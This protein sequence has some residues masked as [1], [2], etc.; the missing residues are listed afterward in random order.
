MR[1][2]DPAVRE[3]LRKKCL[4]PRSDDYGQLC[5]QLSKVLDAY[6]RQSEQLEA[7]NALV[8][9]HKGL[10]AD[11]TASVGKFL[12]DLYVIMVDPLSEGTIKIDVVCEALTIAAKTDRD[13]IHLMQAQLAE[14]DKTIAEKDAEI[15]GLREAASH[16]A[17]DT[18]GSTA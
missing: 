8:A 6:E 1:I 9:A 3:A 11:H 2:E 5:G 7:A 16:R 14:R 15:A 4:T 17:G 18:G 13:V 12:Q 10:F